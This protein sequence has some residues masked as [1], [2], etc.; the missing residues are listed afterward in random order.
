MIRSTAS[1]CR[2]SIGT[3]IS[4]EYAG[5][6][7]AAPI[8]STSWLTP[9]YSSLMSARIAF[10]NSIGDRL[11]LRSTSKLI[12]GGVSGSADASSTNQLRVRFVNHLLR[13]SEV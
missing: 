3:P 7:F 9:S 10:S 6:T 12:V 1:M 2:P 4:H 11:G 8:L 5:S 13:G